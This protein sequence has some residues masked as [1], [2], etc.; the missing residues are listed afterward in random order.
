MHR[1]HNL[2]KCKLKLVIYNDY[3]MPGAQTI[4]PFKSQQSVLFK[5]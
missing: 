2:I 5:F 4:E 3:L 1:T